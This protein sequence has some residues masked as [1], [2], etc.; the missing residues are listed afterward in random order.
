MSSSEIVVK[1]VSDINTN[2]NKSGEAQPIGT[3]QRK[4]APSTNGQKVVVDDDDDDDWLS[5]DSL[6]KNNV[7]EVKKYHFITDNKLV[8]DNVS[9][10][11]AL[12]GDEDLRGGF[13]NVAHAPDNVNRRRKRKKKTWKMEPIPIRPFVQ[14]PIV[15]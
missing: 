13:E 1:S 9:Y 7:N 2:G 15:S 6:H 8:D 12:T 11:S 5:E 14:V 4:I 3:I 10:I